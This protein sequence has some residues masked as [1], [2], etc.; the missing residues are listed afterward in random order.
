MPGY[1]GH[2]A[3]GLMLFLMILAIV[4][5]WCMPTTLTIV[6]WGA[7]TLAGSL[8]PDIDT[9]SKGQRLFYLLML[10]VFGILIVSHRYKALAFTSVM[11]MVPLI[12]HHRGVCHRLWFVLLVPFATALLL[13]TIMPSY[14]SML[15]L[16]ALFF[17]IGAISHLWLDLGW[18]RMM[19]F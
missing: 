9:K 2:L 6:E 1:R 17:S 15:L 13:T 19:R 11:A 8:F 4:V 10:L 16:D 14:Q 7:C 3:G 12:V 5:H 18:R